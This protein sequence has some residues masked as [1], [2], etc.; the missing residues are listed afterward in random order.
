MTPKQITSKREK[1]LEISRK[2][3]AM[4]RELTDDIMNELEKLVKKNGGRITFKHPVD[5]KKRGW[6]IVAY[7]I[8][9]YDYNGW[10]MDNH[11]E[12]HH[13]QL[14]I[15]RGNNLCAGIPCV[16]NHPKQDTLQRLEYWAEPGNKPGLLY[17]IYQEVVNTLG[18]K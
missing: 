16:S 8:V 18:M 15:D 17:D 2:H 14:C 11:C 4:M 9:W 5:F 12:E 7:S 10:D 3:K 6:S 1:M 13:E